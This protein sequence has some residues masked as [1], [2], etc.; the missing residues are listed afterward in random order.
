MKL[1]TK[2]NFE[3]TKI[4]N[5]FNEQ[6]ENVVSADIERLSGMTKAIHEAVLAYMP[7]EFTSAAGEFFESGIDWQGAID[8]LVDVVSEMR[9]R[10]EHAI[11]IYC[12]INR[13]LEG[14]E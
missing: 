10:R 14:E 12:E 13:N 3:V 9:A 11:S 8:E 1:S 4:E 6:D 5:H 2:D 7:T